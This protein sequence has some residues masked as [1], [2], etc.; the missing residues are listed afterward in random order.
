MKSQLVELLGLVH[1][2]VAIA[3]L[4]APPAGLKRV[5]KAAPASCGYWRRAADGDSFY[6]TADDHLSCAVGAHTHG[7][8]TNA[9]QKAQLMQLIQTMVGLEYLS[10]DEVPQIPHRSPD[11][12]GVVA[13]APLDRAGFKPDVVLIRGDVR[14][15]MLL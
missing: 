11:G 5:A 3:F 10:M 2:P 12:F 1:A 7:V 8:P 13:Y 4:P 15:L 6:T 14:Q 9:E